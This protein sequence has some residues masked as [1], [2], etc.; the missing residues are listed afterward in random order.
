MFSASRR[1][2]PFRLGLFL[3][4]WGL[5]VIASFLLFA[6]LIGDG[7]DKGKT[8]LA[9]AKAKLEAMWNVQLPADAE[10]VGPAAEPR[11]VSAD[12]DLRE[13]GCSGAIYPTATLRL[14]E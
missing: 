8:E 11:V 1:V 2:G 12:W 5:V 10:V 4:A 9:C 7:S 6:S 14:R 13:L 3:I